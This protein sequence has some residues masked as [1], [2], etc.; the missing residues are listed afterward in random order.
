MAEQ[1]AALPAPGATRPQST[2]GAD[3][4]ARGI[5]VR[6]APRVEVPR[7]QRLPRRTNVNIPRCVVLKLVSGKES[8]RF[9]PVRP[10]GRDVGGDPPGLELAVVFGAA[11]LPVRH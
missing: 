8:V 1:G 11:I 9:P 5:L 3:A 7:V 2:S 10:A 6:L 4:F